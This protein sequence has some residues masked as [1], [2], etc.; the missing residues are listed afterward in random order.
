MGGSNLLHSPTSTLSFRGQYHSC[1][2]SKFTYSHNLKKAISQERLVLE[3][4]NFLQRGFFTEKFDVLRGR[5]LGNQ[6]NFHRQLG[7]QINHQPCSCKAAR[8]I[9]CTELD[10][11]VSSLK[12][13]SAALSSAVICKY[14]TSGILVFF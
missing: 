1:V 10:S 4:W 7:G 3:R 6:N 2:F 13:S 12:L 11:A 8:V 14:R 5:L 9:I